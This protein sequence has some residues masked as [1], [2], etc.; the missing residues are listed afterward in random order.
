[1]DSMVS[2]TTAALR[3]QIDRPEPPATDQTVYRGAMAN[4]P[5]ANSAALAHAITFRHPC[6]LARDGES[7]NYAPDVSQRTK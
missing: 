3:F 4:S 6:T 2:E 5:T 1:M 7:R